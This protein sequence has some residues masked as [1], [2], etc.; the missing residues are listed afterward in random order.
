[1]APTRSHYGV[2]DSLNTSYGAA[3]QTSFDAGDMDYD[4]FVVQRRL[5]ARLRRGRLPE[6]VNVALGIEARREEYGIEA[7]EPAS[8]NRGPVVGRAGGRARLPGFPTEQ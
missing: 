3:S 8:Y 5:R 6:P 7:G 4:Q 2:E 1:M